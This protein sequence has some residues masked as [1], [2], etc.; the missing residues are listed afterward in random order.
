GQIV[1]Q[2]QPL[3]QQ[4][5]LGA[6]CTGNELGARRQRRPAATHFERGVAQHRSRDALRGVLV[7]GRKRRGRDFGRGGLRRGRLLGGLRPRLGRGGRS[8]RLG[9]RR[10]GKNRQRQ[11]RDRH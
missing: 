5:D 8:A 4:C 11:K 7:E 3:A 10:R 6:L 9:E 2:R 1:G